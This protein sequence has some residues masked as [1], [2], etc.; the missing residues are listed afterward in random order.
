[1]HVWSTFL[2]YKGTR[3]EKKQH[4]AKFD[5]SSLVSFIDQNVHAYSKVEVTKFPLVQMKKYTLLQ[6]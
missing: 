6:I 1:M 3:I 5:F 2:I 4:E